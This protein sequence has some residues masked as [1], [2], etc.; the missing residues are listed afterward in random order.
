MNKLSRSLKAG[1]KGYKAGLEPIKPAQYQGGGHVIHCL[2]C[3]GEVFQEQDTG[4]LGLGTILTCDRCGLS[5]LY[6]KKP[7]RVL[8]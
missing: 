2:Q 4:L 6:G 3:G 8:R 7:E 5:Q 1:I